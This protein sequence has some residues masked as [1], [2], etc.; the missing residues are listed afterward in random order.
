MNFDLKSAEFW[1]PQATRKEV[2][3]VFDVCH[4]C[5]VCQTICPSFVNLFQF[6]DDAFGNVDALSEEQI[7]NVF[8]LCYQ[9]K[10]CYPI[11][12]YIPPHEWDIDFP[13]TVTR[14]NLVRKKQSGPTLADKVFGDADMVGTLA[15]MAPGLANWANTNPTMRG[16]LEKYLGVHKDRLLPTFHEIGRAH[17]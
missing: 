2:L 9:C 14:A 1:D 6:V 7:G 3:R 8:D 11:C 17:V 13:R 10:L 12:P 15:S 4:G 16:L 5:R